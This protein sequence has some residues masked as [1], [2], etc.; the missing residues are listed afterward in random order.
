MRL[1]AGPGQTRDDHLELAAQLY[2][3][4]SEAQH[5]ADLADVVGA[6]ALG[7]IPSAPI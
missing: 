4:V 1:S 7:E 3:L 2:A 5:A 6:D